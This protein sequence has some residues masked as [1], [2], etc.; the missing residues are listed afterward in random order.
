M[1]TTEELP[2]SV[3]TNTGD[4]RVRLPLDRE[5]RDSYTFSVE[6]S[7]SSPF[8]PLSSSVDVV[9]SVSDVNDNAPAF[10]NG[11][12][13]GEEDYVEDKR[14]FFV[15]PETKEGDFIFGE[16]KLKKEG[17]CMILFERFTSWSCSATQ[18]CLPMTL[19]LALTGK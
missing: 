12:V 14:D 10:V 2:F 15:S 19:T 4:I 13:D 17:L 16:Q 5:R 8:A 1:L 7:D 6:A 18:V 11:E 3:D 9:V